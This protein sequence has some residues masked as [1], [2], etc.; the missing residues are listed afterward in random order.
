MSLYKNQEEAIPPVKTAYVTLINEPLYA[1]NAG[2]LL[3]E[4]KL[5]RYES[6]S[7][8][9]TPTGARITPASVTVNYQIVGDWVTLDIGTLASANAEA[10][11]VTLDLSL[12]KF[13]TPAATKFAPI[14]VYENG[15]Q[16]SGAMK[17][18]T[19]GSQPSQTVTLNIGLLDSSSNVTTT[20][21]G[22]TAAAGCGI[23]GG[24]IRYQSGVTMKV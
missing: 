16:V 20:L 5:D 12:P 23:I 11:T 8:T 24:Q 2:G 19:S 9:V 10:G 22:F 17:I 18:S 13:L 21:T 4:A 1:E 7:F 15:G 3:D 14:L 6:G